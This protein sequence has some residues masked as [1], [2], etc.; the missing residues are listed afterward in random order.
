MLVPGPGWNLAN[1][2]NPDASDEE[3]GE[4][5]AVGQQ[6]ADDPEPALSCRSFR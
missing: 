2:P 3:L 5:E 4:V 1:S 6:V